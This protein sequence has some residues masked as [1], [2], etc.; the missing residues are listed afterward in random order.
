MRSRAQSSLRKC[1]A[2]FPRGRFATEN[3]NVR[4]GIR[5][6]AEEVLEQG[7]RSC[8]INRVTLLGP[9]DRDNCHPSLSTNG[10]GFCHA[11]PHVTGDPL[12]ERPAVDFLMRRRG[13]VEAARVGC[14]KQKNCMRRQAAARTA[15]Y[16][17]SRT[18][19]VFAKAV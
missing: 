15:L 6:K 1:S 12:R 9:L 10:N 16:L 17:T 18:Q 5:V 7:V 2:V 11:R 14:K 3:G 19:S 8:T 13:Y 4:S